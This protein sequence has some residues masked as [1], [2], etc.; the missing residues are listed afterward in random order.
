[1]SNQNY[2]SFNEFLNTFNINPSLNESI[3]TT[4]FYPSGEITTMP[5]LFYPSISSTTTS[6]YFTSSPMIMENNLPVP[7]PMQMIMQ[8]NPPVPT[9]SPPMPIQHPPITIPH[10][11]MIMQNIP[12]P[13]FIPWGASG[14]NQNIT[15]PTPP[16][17]MIMDHMGHTGIFHV[18]VPIPSPTPMGWNPSWGAT[19]THPPDLVAHGHSG[20]TG[21]YNGQTW[22][23]IQKK[24]LLSNKISFEDKEFSINI[25][26]I[27]EPE[28]KFLKRVYHLKCKDLNIKTILKIDEET[29]EP[30]H[31]K[32]FDKIIE[33]IEKLSKMNL[34][35]SNICKSVLIKDI[36][37]N[38]RLN[39]RFEIEI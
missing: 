36:F 33:V 27:N 16:S 14:T 15:V 29:F 13:T 2:N 11:Q 4:M 12:I 10:P 24:T 18:P 22:V 32:K 31:N 39:N 21:Y 37:M 8:N 3:N 28:C 30:I 6:S 5:T 25:H 38:K 35:Y 17:Q 34:Y 26:Y 23:A 7:T 9:P 19:G 1:M 20:H